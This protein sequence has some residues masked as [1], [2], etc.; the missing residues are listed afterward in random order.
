MLIDLATE[1]KFLRFRWA[2]KEKDFGQFIKV[3]LTGSG[4]AVS[5]EFSHYFFVFRLAG[6][7]PTTLFTSSTN[8]NKGVQLSGI[9]DQ[10]ATRVS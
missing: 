4:G 9:F 3:E 10:E 8:I 2:L 1:N 7:R 6:V 5:P